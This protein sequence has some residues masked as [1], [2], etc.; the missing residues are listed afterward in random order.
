MLQG[1][2]TF[3][4]F[5][6]MVGSPF[7]VQ[8]QAQGEKLRFVNKIDRGHDLRDTGLGEMTQTTLCKYI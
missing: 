6:L 5:V 7:Q 3:G 1:K 2:S 4:T 8:A